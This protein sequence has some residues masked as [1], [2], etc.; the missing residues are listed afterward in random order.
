MSALNADLE[1]SAVERIVEKACAYATRNRHEFVTLEHLMLML[2]DEESSRNLLLNCGVDINELQQDLLGY[3]NTDIPQAK[4]ARAAFPSPGLQRTLQRATAA[5]QSLGVGEVQPAHLLTALFSERESHAVYFLQKQGVSRTDVS[6]ALIHGVGEHEVETEAEAA[7]PA[8]TAEPAAAAKQAKGGLP[9]HLQP[10]LVDLN[11]KAKSGK[12]DPVIGR[13]NEIELCCEVLL[14]RTKNNPLLVGEP[15]VG[16][17]AI[18]EGLALRIVEGSAPAFLRDCQIYSL[19]MGAL[20]GGTRFRGD[21]EERL[22]AII[23]TLEKMEN[24]ILFID[25]VHTVVGAGSGS[26]GA[27]DAS[28]IMKPAL[29]RGAVRCLGAT[30]YKEYRKHFENDE[31]LARRFQ[32]IDVQEPSV[33][34][35]IAMLG[36]IKGYYESHHKVA[37]DEAAIK[38]AV[39]LSVRYITDRRLPDKAIDVI[40]QA[41]SMAA[42]KRYAT[43]ADTARPSRPTAKVAPVKVVQPGAVTK[44][45]VAE[46]EAAVTKIARL[47]PKAVAK[48]EKTALR[49]MDADLKAVV[50]DQDEAVNALT[51][52][53][54]MARLGLR[55]PEKPIGSYLFA[56]PT[57]VGK[58]EIA[59]QLAS[60][61]DVEL[62][63]FDMSEYMERH[64]VSRLIGAPPGYVGFDQ[65]GLLTDKVSQHPNCVLLLDEIEK[66]HPDLFNLMLQVMDH[67]KLTDNNGK[68][69]DFRNVT[70]IMTT[71]AGGTAR[72]SEPIGFATAPTAGGN[73]DAAMAEISR[74]FTPEFR[75]RL[76]SIVMFGQLS[77]AAIRK[78]VTK[79][80]GQLRAQIAEQDFA[81][82]IDDEAIDW[83]SEKGFDPKMGARP[84]ARLIDKHIRRPL[85]EAILFGDLDKGGRVV[86]RV[87]DGKLVTRAA[88]MEIA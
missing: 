3:V 84:L 65:G 19:D 66:A 2:L 69:I 26:T 6:E 18:V 68:V 61:L 17:T 67:G 7:V 80:I 73:D 36:G 57:G 59:R 77:T 34:D 51:D 24:T 37:Y 1:K 23:T 29:A 88:E 79:F 14:R 82:D 45:S 31:A 54:R 63:R 86:I 25:E 74:T 44:I 48:D 47:K 53:V 9:K 41:G 83:L 20:V 58:T 15:G 71:N 62:L 64:S 4:A 22:K 52:S 27:L 21:F 5:A 43:E 11:A 32:K 76:T 30:T 50:F 35:A 39:N 49:T 16:K 72:Q 38:A 56:G 12:I 78:V 55:D 40:D 60:I 42:M 46:I 81:I 28:N 33:E 87:A 85:A 75:N 70:L 13:S 10:F 8:A